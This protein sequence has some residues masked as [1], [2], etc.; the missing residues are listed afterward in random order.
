VS[1]PQLLE[2]Q[3]FIAAV[4]AQVYLQLESLVLV[5]MEVAEQVVLL[6]L[7]LYQEQQVEVV[8][9]AGLVLAL[10][11]RVLADLVL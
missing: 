11:P 8:E 9:V 4:V 1:L 2:L 7:T 5:V 3:R 6:E 10:E